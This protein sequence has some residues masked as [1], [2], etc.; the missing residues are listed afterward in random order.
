MRRPKRMTKRPCR[1]ELY[2]PSKLMP[3][4]R[5]LADKFG[6]RLIATAANPA[7][8][9]T[10]MVIEFLDR[11]AA[12]RFSEAVDLVDPRCNVLVYRTVQD[13]EV[14]QSALGSP[15]ARPRNH[16]SAIRK[17]RRK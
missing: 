17:R 3:L 1:M 4:V 15:T 9:Q 5:E 8:A 7:A 13:L 16:C 10:G 14:F 12:E 2:L 6:H 11:A